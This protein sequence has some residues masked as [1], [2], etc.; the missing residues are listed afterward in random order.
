MD[1]PARVES[2]I[3]L[4][5]DAQI[6]TA[7]D[8][9]LRVTAGEFV[10]EVAPKSTAAA[11]HLHR[12]LGEL[13]NGHTIAPVQSRQTQDERSFG[14]LLEQL[15]HRHLL[16]Q[17]AKHEPEDSPRNVHARLV[18]TAL[19]TTAMF[20]SDLDSYLRGDDIAPGV[21]HG[22]AIEYFHVTN[23]AIKSLAPALRHSPASFRHI[24]SDMI[25]E[26]Y[27]HDRIM[28]AGVAGFGTDRTLLASL[29]PL[30]YTRALIGRLAAAARRDPGVFSVL[31]YLFERDSPEDA[32]FVSLLELAGAPR[33]FVHAVREHDRINAEGQHSD[34]SR[35]LFE[36]RGLISPDEERRLSGELW[37]AANLFAKYVQ[38][39]VTYY[40]DSSR[41]RLRTAAAVAEELSSQTP[42]PMGAGPET[43]TETARGALRVV[44][45]HGAACAGSAYA[46]TQD[47]ETAN[48][49]SEIL[50]DE[51][52]E[53]DHDSERIVAQ[54]P[55][56][57]FP[58]CDRLDELSERDPAQYLGL[59]HRTLCVLLDT[60]KS[61][62][63]GRDE[64]VMRAA[65]LA[66]RLAA[67]TLMTTGSRGSE[68]NVVDAEW[69][70]VLRREIEQGQAIGS[71]P[72]A[73]NDV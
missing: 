62:D 63:T 52:D 60:A 23:L 17:C 70:A 41:P 71:V 66:E 67:S 20:P 49:I 5:R 8:G 11:E 37:L 25:R 61:G 72:I 36:T 64:A 57:I 3:R 42:T 34:V 53:A 33:E 55:L 15:G 44:L 45:Q 40:R 18:T 2:S 59:F 38:S 26:E 51:Q 31:I 7:P 19:A 32:E 6:R 73:S 65:T 16:V 46:S 47:D 24:V 27:G 12:W 39:M 13:R 43:V 68:A 28:A 21:L 35:S 29:I 1:I 50:L 10:V 48:A 56:A 54:A 30:P 58:I 22:L 4:R 69:L 9:R 14:A